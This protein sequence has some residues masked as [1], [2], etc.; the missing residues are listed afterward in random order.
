SGYAD[1]AL[2]QAA[3]LFQ[4]A[5]EHGGTDRDR[6]SAARLLRLLTREYPKSSLVPQADARLR[7]LAAR[8][9]PVA[10]AKAPAVAARAPVPP[11]DPPATNM[12]SAA[13]P[14]RASTAELRSIARTALPK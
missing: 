14:P 10:T 4:L 1:N 6:D 3:G 11:A 9:A 13:A 2:W 12:T 8:T 7:A 5:S